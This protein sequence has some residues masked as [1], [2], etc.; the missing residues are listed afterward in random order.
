MGGP[1]MIY[2]IADG[3]DRIEV[4]ADSPEAAAQEWANQFDWTGCF[5]AFRRCEIYAGEQPLGNFTHGRFSLIEYDPFPA[6][7]EPPE[8]AT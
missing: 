7:S 8:Q 1:I 6:P 5:V 2:T 4:E 3:P